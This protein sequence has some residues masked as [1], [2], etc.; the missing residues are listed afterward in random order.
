MFPMSLKLLVPV[1]GLLAAGGLG[2]Q[3]H[4]IARPEALLPAKVPD[5]PIRPIDAEADDQTAQLARSD[6]LGFLQHCLDRYDAARVR[7]YTCTFITEQRINGSLTPVQE[8]R[9]RFR[10][11]PFSVDMFFVRNPV[12]AQRAL[13]V[14]DAWRDDMGR[15]LAWFKPAG[16]IV[17]LFVP[18]IQQ[19]ISGQRAKANSRRT[20]DEFGFRRTLEVILKYSQRGYQN[21]ELRLQFIGQG[22]IDGRSTYVFER[23]LPYTGQEEPYPDALLRYHIDRE[24]LVPTGC[25]SFAD[26]EGRNLLGSYVTTDIRFNVGLMDADFDPT[27][28]GF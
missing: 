13:Y 12:D 10:E 1:V 16:A 17:K 24:W 23:H 14:Q 27:K 3:C 7:D 8:A 21:Q 19:P 2:L 4:Q 25:Y 20:L 9:V 6:P 11:R 5:T 28:L 18:K 15:E 22:Q 26:H